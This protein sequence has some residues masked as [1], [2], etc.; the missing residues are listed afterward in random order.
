MRFKFIQERQTEFPVQMTC[1]ILDV[2][3]SGYYAWRDR[4]PCA[5]QQR[6]AALMDQI[7]DV[8]KQSRGS[9]GSPRVTVELKGQGVEVS[10]N[11]VAR[12][13]RESSVCVKPN[14]RF[15]PRTLRALRLTFKKSR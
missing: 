7:E 9:Y 13:R 10:E 6:R 14:R 12:Y 5:R 15:V 1:D 8:H 2:S 4:P 11:T 3:R